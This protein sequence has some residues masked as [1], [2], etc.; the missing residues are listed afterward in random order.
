MKT[1]QFD[2]SQEA[3]DRF[4][5]LYEGLAGTTRQLTY[6]EK[7]MLDKVMT[8]LEDAGKLREGGAG[9]YT[10][11]HEAEVLLED[12][13]ALLVELCHESVPWLNGQW[14][15]KAGRVMA[16]FKDA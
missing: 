16:W 1:L 10:L 13:E 12:A 14:Q 11:A 6:P 3:I 9:L 7:R 4:E 15:R 8:K 5:M 2:G